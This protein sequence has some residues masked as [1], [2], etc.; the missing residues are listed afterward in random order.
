MEVLRLVP[1][2][3]DNPVG[4]DEVSISA[5]RDRQVTLVEW[6]HG[7]PVPSRETLITLIWVLRVEEERAGSRGGAG[8][9]GCGIVP[10]ATSGIKIKPDRQKRSR[11]GDFKRYKSKRQRID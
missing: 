4:G 1:D 11:Y 6:F 2:S 8:R 5:T 7:C 3:S 10:E 9:A